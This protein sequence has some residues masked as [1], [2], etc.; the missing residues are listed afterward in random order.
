VQQKTNNFTVCLRISS[1][2]GTQASNKA[3]LM[4]LYSI[5]RLKITTAEVL[6]EI[7][8]AWDLLLQQTR[9]ATLGSFSYLEYI[10]IRLERI[11]TKT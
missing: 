1:Y 2:G 7:H 9:K 3:S 8:Q 4:R 6:A 10:V 11:S 5:Q